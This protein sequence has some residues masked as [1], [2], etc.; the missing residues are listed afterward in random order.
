MKN[1]LHLYPHGNEI[2]KNHV[3]LFAI[4]KYILLDILKEPD[5]T[6]AVV[7]SIDRSIEITEEDVGYKIAWEIMEKEGYK[8]LIAEINPTFIE[9]DRN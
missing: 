3:V 1:K 9:V 8:K 4:M 5:M 2:T 6:K 7:E